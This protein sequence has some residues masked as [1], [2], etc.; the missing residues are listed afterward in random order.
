[1][2]HDKKS[3]NDF[4]K[5]FE[6][7]KDYLNGILLC[8]CFPKQINRI[9]LTIFL[10]QNHLYCLKVKFIELT[11]KEVFNMQK[12][13]DTY[14][15]CVNTGSFMK[16]QDSLC[17]ESPL[18]ASNSKNDL[19]IL[20]PNDITISFDFL[21]KL[22]LQNKVEVIVYMKS[23]DFPIFAYFIKILQDY[24]N[25]IMQIDPQIFFEIL[26]YLNIFR[27]K[28]N[29]NYK[30]LIKTLVY[31]SVI[32]N[33]DFVKD[34]TFLILNHKEYNNL[35]VRDLI[36]CFLKLIL[37]NKTYIYKMF[38]EYH[39]IEF[40]HILRQHKEHKIKENFV[41]IDLVACHLYKRLLKANSLDKWNMMMN[42]FL[43]DKLYTNFC[44][45]ENELDSETILLLL[46]KIL[47]SF[48]ATIKQAELPLFDKLHQLG[49]FKTVKN[50]KIINIGLRFKLF[51]E[52]LQYFENVEKLALEFLTVNFEED[53][54][55]IENSVV[56]KSIKVLKLFF[57]R[58]LPLLYKASSIYLSGTKDNIIVDLS[59]DLE[60]SDIENK[61]E[62]FSTYNLYN[63]LCGIDLNLHKKYYTSTYFS[64]IFNYK[65]IK[66][67]KIN[68]K[69]VKDNCLNCY[70]FLESFNN[71]KKLYF[72]NIKLTDKLLKVILN[73][74]HLTSV[75]FF[76]FKVFDITKD[77]IISN[78]YNESVIYIKLIQLVDTLNSNFFIFLSKFKNLKCLFFNLHILGD[79][80]DKN[81]FIEDRISKL[82]ISKLKNLENLPLLKCVRYQ[83]NFEIGNKTSFS[84]LRVLS[85]FFNLENLEELTY[86]IGCL[87]TD[88]IIVFSKFKVL[89]YLRLSI[90]KKLSSFDILN[91][92]LQLNIKNT[93]IKLDLVAEKLE[94]FEIFFILNF[95][96][97]KILEIGIF[98]ESGKYKEWL[99]SLIGMNLI[100][101]NI[102]RFLP[103]PIWLGC[104]LYKQNIFTNS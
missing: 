56:L 23:N 63:Y 9:I 28:R 54:V 92:I 101:F 96:R 3:V 39:P 19:I 48:T 99:E 4:L 26:K 74:N 86:S 102:Y 68:L 41:C 7:V 73:S 71:L 29:K 90:Q 31:Y 14:F 42:I 89:K 44:V 46:P 62:I 58:S 12:N 49:F 20:Y 15:L 61:Y 78:F 66:R 100:Y 50:V 45:Y 35:Q 13:S 55:F 47:I 36:E 59:S 69:N 8:L 52:K 5:Y 17:L 10:F 97:L 79:S 51:L 72:E 94:K 40:S 32:S 6:K 65:L 84:I 60:I 82:N 87:Y 43:I 104:G 1:M 25:I 93:I 67:L 83:N 21:D 2:Y 80:N 103:L 64:K 88:D 11:G 24:D 81:Y 27:V 22:I 85:Y 30:I 53:M 77:G 18:A 76:K 16:I 57:C 70:E 75:I 98:L 38:H 33:M 37:M 95:K 34:A 91:E